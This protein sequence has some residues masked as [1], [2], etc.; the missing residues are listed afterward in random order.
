M[1]KLELTTRGVA[2]L[3]P[4]AHAVDYWSADPAEAGFGVRVFPSGVKSWFYYTRQT[5]SGKAVRVT[6]GTFPE[7]GLAKAGEKMAEE[8][9]KVK[10]GQDPAEARRVERAAR[11]R[12]VRALFDAYSRH[13]AVRRQ[14]GEFRSWPDVRR[15]LERDVLPAW[16]DRPA[17]DIRRKDVIELVT[18]K[19]LDGPIAANRLQ[20]HI[21]M[22]FAYGT[23]T[24]WITG[25]P[26]ARLRKRK[27]QPRDRVLSAPELRALWPVLEDSAALTLSR[28]GPKGIP[29]VMTAGTG[30]ALR[31]LFKLLLQT[32]TRL[33]ETSRMTWADVDLEAKIWT[34]PATDTKNR[35]PHRVPLSRQAAAILER[36]RAADSLSP[37][38]FPSAPGKKTSAFVWAKR[39]APV[40]ARA[41]GVAFTAHDLRRTVA[42]QLGELGISDDVIGLV[43]HHTKAG[44]TGRHY[45]HSAREA[46]KAAALER[47]ADRLNAIVTGKSGD[48]VPMAGRR[49]RRA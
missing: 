40:F 29:I 31:D 11:R 19:K 6:L 36:R 23:E 46:A 49:R 33:G 9:A 47:W 32:G 25:N 17:S 27:E 12:T 5:A 2:A 10:V 14:A 16:G 21:S 34:I 41:A 7:M 42:T 48:V 1:P 37:F 4:A 24:D 38:V 39:A 20:A 43:L 18:A 8:R 26:A 45:D 22:L 13:V 35:T 3:R 15:S 28:G 44:V 30:A